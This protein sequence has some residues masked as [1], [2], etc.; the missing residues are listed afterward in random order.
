MGHTPTWLASRAVALTVLGALAV[1]L[2]APASLLPSAAHAAP[3]GLDEPSEPDAAA[4]PHQAAYGVRSFKS[5]PIQT[6]ANGRFVWVANQYADSVSRYDT[7][8]GAVASF[9][10]PDLAERDAPRGLSVTEDG[11]HVWVAAHDSDKL[12]VLNGESGAIVKTLAMPWG[13]GPE[14]VVPRR[15]MG[16]A[17]SRGRWWPSIGPRRW[18]R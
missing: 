2:A 8:S 10:L 6:T 17:A 4:G 9:V 12:F 1:T 7:Q 5:G 11:S 18:R 14:W 15:P 3:S 13:S 16:Q